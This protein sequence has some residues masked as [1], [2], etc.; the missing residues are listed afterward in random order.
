MIDVAAGIL[1]RPDGRVLLA[2]RPAGKPW[3]GYWEFPGGKIELGEQPIAALARELHEELGIEVDVATPWITFVYDYPEKSVRLHFFRV[4]RWHGD[5]HGRET[6]RLSWEDPQAITVQPLLPANDG[7][8]W[9]LNLPPVYAITQAGKYGIPEFLSRLDTQLERGLRLIQVRE[10]GMDAEALKRLAGEIVQRAHRHG[11]RV[12]INGDAA[13]AR[14]VGADGLHLP[15]RQFLALH[16]PPDEALWAASCHDATELA[17]AVA[18]GARF[19]VLSPV[20]PTASHPGAP[21]LGWEKFETLVRDRPIPVY[22]L[23]GMSP[24]LLDTAMQ[25]GA[26]GVAVLSGIW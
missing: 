8:L 15:A 22:A 7:V 16:Q 5:P 17:R 19:A 11:A 1:L 14:A 24:A 4:S 23:G 21:V 26:H 9:A 2:E 13:L 25:H 12:L 6:Q 18:L 20:L 3:A 10:P